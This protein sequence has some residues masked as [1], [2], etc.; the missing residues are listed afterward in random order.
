MIVPH[1]SRIGLVLLVLCALYQ[2]AM[3]HLQESAVELGFVRLHLF[4]IGTQA[5][6]EY[7][8]TYK[9]LLNLIRSSH[10][11]SCSVWVCVCVRVKVYPIC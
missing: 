6:I 4:P 7:V 3:L 11:L 10:L 5:T 1:P 8:Y 2:L 9:R